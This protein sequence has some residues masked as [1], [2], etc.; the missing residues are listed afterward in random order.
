[1][2]KVK[3]FS[4]E[5]DA[6]NGSL[7]Y[8]IEFKVNKTELYMLKLAKLLKLKLIKMTIMMIA[9]MI[10]IIRKISRLFFYG[11]ICMDFICSFC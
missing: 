9:M 5:L 6:E 7:I 1:L 8:E 2:N 3:G 4:I 10:N 11:L